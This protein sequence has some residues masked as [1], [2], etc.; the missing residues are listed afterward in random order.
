MGV[1]GTAASRQ[2][3]EVLRERAERFYKDATRGGETELTASR[4]LEHCHN[5][6]L[7]GEN[8]EEETRVLFATF[9]EDCDDVWNFNEF[10]VRPEPLNPPAPQP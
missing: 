1:F 3:A 7:V 8:E 6:G 4:L 5:L 9:D 10:L 2:N